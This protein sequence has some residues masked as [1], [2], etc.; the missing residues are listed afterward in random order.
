MVNGIFNIQSGVRPR[1][2]RNRVGRLPREIQQQVFEHYHRGL[3][4]RRN[5]MLP[6]V[7]PPGFRTHDPGFRHGRG[8]VRYSRMRTR[9]LVN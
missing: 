6:R 1:I 2:R 9:R 5:F 8:A 3:M 7:R 4:G